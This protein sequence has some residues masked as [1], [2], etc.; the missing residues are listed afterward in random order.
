MPARGQS[1]NGANCSLFGSAFKAVRSART[2]KLQLSFPA[3]FFGS[4]F[5]R[6]KNEQIDFGESKSKNGVWGNAPYRIINPPPYLPYPLY[7]SFKSFCLFQ[8]RLPSVNSS[9][10]AG[11]GS[12]F[13]HLHCLCVTA[14]A[15]AEATATRGR[16][17][18]A[19]G[20]IRVKN[21]VVS[22]WRFLI[23][24]RSIPSASL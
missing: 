6:T 8:G 3:P 12:S 17:S 19:S 23:T 11:L 24:L 21:L 7:T 22:I 2:N 9:R 20:F 1:G 4:F 16:R 14:C 13:L 10:K 18:K 5:G 15:S